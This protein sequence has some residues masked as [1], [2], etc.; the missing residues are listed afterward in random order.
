M[1]SAALLEVEGLTV[2][3]RGRPL[4]DGVNLL[5]APGEALGLAGESGCGKTTTALSVM[6]LLPPGLT[7]TGS[8]TLRPPGVAEP[9]NVGRRTGARRSTSTAAPS[10]GCSSCAGA[11]CRSSSRGR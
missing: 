7:Q 10:A 4:V 8:I 6:K 1:S 11:T 9:I 2:R 3:H 5:L